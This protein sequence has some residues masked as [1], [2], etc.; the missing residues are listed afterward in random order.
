[1][2]NFAGALALR[3]G[4]RQ[5]AESGQGQRCCAQL[6]DAP[7]PCTAKSG[8]RVWGRMS[9]QEPT[10]GNDCSR[11]GK[12]AVEHDKLRTWRLNENADGP[13]IPTS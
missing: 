6:P 3:V 2:F 9:G 13:R 11:V 8:R 4:L 7:Q 10:C 5:T 1:M 12:I